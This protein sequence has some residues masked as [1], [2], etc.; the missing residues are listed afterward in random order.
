MTYITGSSDVGLYTHLYI[1]LG[2]RFVLGLRES[3]RSWRDK[4]NEA[5]LPGDTHCHLCDIM[6]L[7]YVSSSANIHK[8][9]APM[10]D[11]RTALHTSRELESTPVQQGNRITNVLSTGTGGNWRDMYTPLGTWFGQKGTLNMAHQHKERLCGTIRNSK[12]GR[13]TFDLRQTLLN[14]PNITAHSELMNTCHLWLCRVAQ[15]FHF[16]N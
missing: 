3:V 14:G 6:A 8:A 7:S 9:W 12:M 11:Q 1:N 4:D 2:A 15:Q 10:N 16:R 5:G 13:K